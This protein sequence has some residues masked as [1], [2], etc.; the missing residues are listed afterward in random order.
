[1]KRVLVFLSVLLLLFSVSAVTASANGPAP[2]P[3]YNFYFIN[4]PED[5]VY[6]DLLIYLPESDPMFVE[7]NER[8]IPDSFSP[9][10][11]ILSYCQDDYRSYTFHYRDALSVINLNA[12]TAS[13]FDSVV[14]FFTSG[15]NYINDDTVRFSHADDIEAR[16]MI[17]LAMLDSEGNMLMI[18]SPQSLRSRV[19]LAYTL[20]S[21]NYDAQTDQLEVEYAISG[22][23]I[24]AYFFVS[25]IGIFITCITEGMVATAFKLDGKYAKLI[26]CTNI[27]SQIAM[28]FLFVLFYSL[29]FWRYLIAVVLLE[30][31]VYTGEYLIYRKKMTDIS[32]K[33]CLLYTV[34]ANSLS[35]IIG[36]V[37]NAVILF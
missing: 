14:S 28:R 1:M 31:L 23:G 12:T 22:F 4:L 30:I 16:G 27:I 37:V 13:G 6:V 26:R 35:W 10:A 11:Q 29:L 9:Y 32:A 3:W 20:G 5:T 34:C 24:I 2:S 15:G 7:V 18:S 25:L 19:F 17:K 21:Y 8:N 33:K 36:A